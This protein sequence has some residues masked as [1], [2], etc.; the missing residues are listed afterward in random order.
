MQGAVFDLDGLIIDSE[1]L[2]RLAEREVFASV[3]LDLSDAD[4]RRTTGMR[5]DKVVDF[6]FE[7]H[8][9]TGPGRVD[10]LRTLE[11]RVIELIRSRGEMLPGV[12]LTI[13]ALRGAGLRLAVA[14]SSAPE[15]IDAALSTLG[16]EGVFE[17][18]CSAADEI[19]PKPDPAVYLTTTGRLGIEPGRCIAFEDSVV[20]VEAARAAGLFV[21]AVP[22]AEQFGEPRFDDADLI[23]RSLEDFALER[24]VSGTEN[25]HL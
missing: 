20:G 4:C 17:V 15:L 6:W 19:H 2:W 8:P 18:V 22:E 24:C 9:W 14:S 13:S 21:V 7:Q 12:D 10:V 25:R 1:P 5:A 23:L 3:G 16:L 11:A